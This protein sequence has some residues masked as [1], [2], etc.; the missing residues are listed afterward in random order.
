MLLDSELKHPFGP[1]RSSPRYVL[2]MDKKGF[3]R[4][5]KGKKMAMNIENLP[6][7]STYFYSYFFDP[8]NK[9]FQMRLWV[10]IGKEI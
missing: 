10:E 4:K 8:Q 9:V 7:I 6:L 3:D 2:S 5:H 1:F